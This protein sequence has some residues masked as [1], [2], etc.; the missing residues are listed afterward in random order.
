M[1]CCSGWRS[2]PALPSLPCSSVVSISGGAFSWARSSPSVITDGSL[3]PDPLPHASSVLGRRCGK[4]LVEHL[5][6]LQEVLSKHHGA[7]G[8]WHSRPPVTDSSLLVVVRG[9]G[10]PGGSDGAPSNVMA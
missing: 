4:S 3:P 5:P 1:P 10:Q 6:N 2:Q 7:V 9:S 8:W